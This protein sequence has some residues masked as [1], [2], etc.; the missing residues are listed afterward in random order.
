M[1]REGD[2]VRL[3]DGRFVYLHHDEGHPLPQYSEG[4]PLSGHYSALFYHP[5]R[6]IGCADWALFSEDRDPQYQGAVLVSDDAV[7]QEFIDKIQDKRQEMSQHRHTSPL[8]A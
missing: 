6:G 1:Y 5:A 8:P 2:I 4:E 7:P 3:R